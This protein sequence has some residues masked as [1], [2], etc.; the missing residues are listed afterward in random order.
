M[1]KDRQTHARFSFK[2]DPF[3]R[4]R[5]AGRIMGE[6]MMAYKE[7]LWSA[8]NTENTMESIVGAAVPCSGGSASGFR[9]QNVDLQSYLSL[10]ALGATASGA[11]GND[12]WGWTDPVT[13][14]EIVVMGT[15]QGTSFVRIT[16]PVNPQVVA[17]L[18][19]HTSS[20]SWR[21][22]KVVNDHAFIGS[23][24]AG[25]GLQVFDLTRLRGQ[26]NMGTVSADA[27]YGQFGNSHNI[28]SNPE[29][30]TI[31]VVGATNDNRGCR[32]GLHM[33]DVSNPKNPTFAGCFSADGYT[34]DAQCHF[35]NGPDTTYRGREICYNYNEDALTI[36]D[37][38]N[39]ASPVEIS[40]TSYVGYAYTHQ[41][42]ITED[43]TV[44]LLDDEQ[45]EQGNWFDGSTVTYIWDVSDLDNPVLRNEYY[46]AHEAI[47]HNQYIRGSRTYQSNYEVGLRILQINQASYSLTEVGYFDVDT[48]STGGLV[49]FRGSWSNYPYFASGNIPVTSIETGLYI[50]KPD[51]MA[52]DA[53]YAAKLNGHQERSRQVLT[54]SAEGCNDVREER[55]CQ[56]TC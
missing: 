35:Y 22:M 18:P 8:P 9:C 2:P 17:W 55:Y 44:I 28:V 48:G 47:D 53:T 41:G 11:R 5:D 33:V 31:F 27:H 4:Y 37:V 3:K 34:H 38:T 1:P 50:V 7:Q 30:N 12:I 56:A 26:T 39:K 16:D 20:S 42:W 19:T 32:A 36:V 6:R 24:A 23:E 13:N 10:S 46:A 14:D 51:N 45:D 43:H 40:S 15:N 29:S 49:A 21:D 52:M 54:E 25:H